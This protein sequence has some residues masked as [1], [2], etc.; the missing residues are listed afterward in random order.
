M[1]D[2][3]IQWI[4]R[5]TVPGE[6]I[7]VHTR[8][9]VCYPEVTGYFIPTLLSLGERGLARQYASFLCRIQQPD[10]SFLDPDGQAPYAFDTGQ[11]IRGW[12]ELLPTQ[13]EL[14]KPLRRACD[15]LMHSAEPATGRLLV[16]RGDA[17][18]MAGR[19]T[20]SEGVH[21]YA[22][23]PMKRAG[24]LLKEQRY[25]DFVE[26]SQRY[27]M[28]K[29]DLTNF[30]QSHMLTHL[31]CY[32]QEGL[33]DLGEHQLARKGMA[34][35]AR[36]QQENGALPG[37][38]DVPWM[39]APGQIQAAIVWYKLGERAR[40]DKALT[41]AEQCMNPSGG[42]FGS[43]GV[44]ADY[45]PGAEL[46]WATKF[47]LD[48][49]QARIT[50]F[51][52]AEHAIFPTQIGAADGRLLAIAEYAGD[53]NDRAVLDVGCGKGRFAAALKERFPRA[54]LD[55]VDISAELLKAVPAVIP[56]RLGSMLQ[57][58]WPDAT[59]DVLYCVEAL[60]HAQCE[61]AALREMNRVLKPGGHLVVIDKNAERWGAFE[62][63]AWEKWFKPEPLAAQLREICGAAEWKFIGYDKQPADGLFVA[64][65]GQ[66]TCEAA[67]AA[68]VLSSNEAVAGDMKVGTAGAKAPAGTRR[69]L[70][71]EEWHEAIT[72]GARP[73]EIAA[74][75]RAGNI[76]E[77]VKPVLELTKPGDVVLEQ[78]SGT[79]AMSAWLALQGRQ[80]V[81]LDYSQ[82]CLDFGLAVF[83]EL[84]LPAPQTICADIRERL[85]LGDHAVDL[86]WS[87]GV[88]EHF[89]DDEI[90]HILA[91]STRV[92]RRQVFS[93]V[94]N[95]RAMAYRV[96]KWDQEQHGRWQYGYEDPKFS[97][98][99]LFAR[100]G[101]RAVREFTVGPL[102]AINFLDDARFAP[103]RQALG[104]FMRHLPADQ[105]Q[106]L[107]QGYLLGTVGS[108]RA[109][110]RIAVVPS[111]SLADYEQ[112]G[113]G[114]WLEAYYNPAGWFDEVYC[115]SPKE[116][117]SRVAHGMKIIPTQPGELAAR[118]R[119]LN[120][121]VVR[122]YGGYWACDFA[123][124]EKV[125]GVPVIVSVHD[126]RPD[127][128]HDS[129]RNADQVIAVSE[130]VRRLVVGRGVP[131]KQIVTIPNRVDFEVFRQI[132]E[133]AKRSAFE[134][135][136]PGQHRILHV[137]RKSAQKN[138]D[139][140]IRTLPL[141][142]E[143][144]TV[145]AVGRGDV[146]PY[147]KLADELG[148][149]GRC[150]FVESVPSAELPEFYSFCDCFCTPSRHEGFGI[151]FIEALACGAVVVAPDIAPI[152]EFICDHGN[153]LLVKQA[154]DPIAFA[155]AIRRACTDVDL[156]RRLSQAARPSVQ[157]FERRLVDALEAEFYDRVVSRRNIPSSPTTPTVPPMKVQPH[158]QFAR[159][160]ARLR[161]SKS[162][163][164]LGC[165]NH[166][167]AGATAAV[168]LH[169][170]P[171]ERALGHGA[172]ID[173]EALGRRGIRFVNARVDGPLPFKDKEFDFAYSHHVF[174]HLDDP[175]AACREMVRIAKAGAIIT[176]A[177]FAEF[178]FG[179][180]YHRWLVTE[181]AGK[182]IFLNKRAEEDRP[183]GQHP[184]F[185][186]DRGWFTGPE[187][188]PFDL[189]L[190]DGEWYHGSESEQ[191]RRL[192]ERLRQL[193]YSH[194]PVIETLFLWEDSF[195]CLVLGESQP[196][197]P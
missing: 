46:S 34:H 194:S 125:P 54:R 91:E 185:A 2:Q 95:A 148:V 66:K 132:D 27:Y 177:P 103:A 105:L 43:Y 124:A 119:E 72:A 192:S 4:K 154:E 30:E 13:P 1:I 84:G 176:P 121:D 88:L 75:V 186:P 170:A 165:G 180:P 36:F 35:L 101:L 178:A 129:I 183:F 94:P 141:L 145:I 115:L 11:V 99:P 100:A 23:W 135:R 56:T 175:A 123:T 25:L 190:N 78:G 191:F 29:V 182:L 126:Q 188:N 90:V 50:Q 69:A 44:A 22:L 12:V 89:S 96:G 16:P 187:T 17:W 111:D 77:W 139:T 93:L 98:A 79:A 142:G 9:R 45:F 189:L 195:E 169:V 147:E 32:I 20:V 166:P 120:I 137:G 26:R 64:W 140:L 60:E 58:P 171:A 67:A 62:T 136:F 19:G 83:R 158:P 63:P 160:Q 134:Q 196:P 6:G 47:Y 184:E 51:F 152:N 168:D 14:E 149:R 5:N 15:W 150:H 81:L 61:T 167:V 68:P 38:F 112:A 39:C 59:F 108:V 172:T 80:V 146:L 114:S 104:D 174:E 197:I 74:G 42:F 157:S 52:D 151:V 92:A 28:G 138:L 65:H 161:A 179:R 87:S 57:L 133:P 24:Q 162:I 163:V 173:V 55:G 159:L 71:S 53:L 107:D 21:L 144:Y 110:R 49:C 7:V 116:T 40:A 102:H 70:D 118:I 156:R 41:F 10:G 86:V 97:L 143:D 113:Y 127:W 131:E 31:F 106:Q 109:P 85:P 73:A 82:A 122:A 128:L 164:D 18:E 76:P 48:A 33:F 3:A 37:Y 117:V 130:L 193:W 153:G 155:A 8:K 181:R